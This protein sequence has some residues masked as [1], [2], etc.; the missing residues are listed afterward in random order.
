MLL[1]PGLWATLKPL[2]KINIS[3]RWDSKVF[4]GVDPF[5]FSEQ[6]ARNAAMREVSCTYIGS[7]SA[8]DWADRGKVLEFFAAQNFINNE[9]SRT[10][11]EGLY[12][13]G[14]LVPYRTGGA[15]LLSVQPVAV[16]VLM[17]ALT[18]VNLITCHLVFHTLSK[19]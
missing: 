9:V 2:T 10:L 7:L 14:A 4:E 8:L 18:S 15:L 1:S 13:G 16:S 19:R 6:A 11:K 17:V 5:D 3:V 12:G